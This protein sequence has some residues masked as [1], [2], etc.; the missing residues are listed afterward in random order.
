[1]IIDASALLAILL[2][3]AEAKAFATILAAAPVARISVVNYLE[4]AIRIDQQN[5]I[6]ATQAFDAFVEMSGMVIEPVTIAQARIARRA[7]AQFGKGRHAAALNFGDSFAYA[8]AKERDEPL[9]FKG[10]DF[11]R[12]DIKRAGSAAPNPASLSP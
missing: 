5:S 2:Q 3:E 10:N 8:L 4:A 12:T 1:M 11:S 6:V 9:L 7:Y